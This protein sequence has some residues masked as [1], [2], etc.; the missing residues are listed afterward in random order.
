MIISQ[1]VRH[2]DSKPSNVFVRGLV[3]GLA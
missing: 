1:S 2:T 3:G